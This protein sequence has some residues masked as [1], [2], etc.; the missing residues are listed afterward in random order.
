[1]EHVNGALTISNPRLLS[2]VYFAVL[3][4]I[5]TIVLK[6]ILY[7]LG[8]DFGIALY[9][10]L[11]LSFFCAAV[12]G[13]LFGDEIIH[14]SAPYKNHVFWWAFLMVIVA[15]PLYTFGFLILLIKNNPETFESATLEH[16]LYLYMA[17]FIY[18]LVFAGI[19]LAILAGIAAIFLRGYLVNYLLES[20]YV[21]RTSPKGTVIGSKTPLHG[22][23]QID[24]RDKH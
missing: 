3:A 14:C 5:I 13:A 6:G 20:L 18:A 1:M 8:V 15:L 22:Q 2:A 4:V 9:Q 11:L 21:K 16:Y 23:Q 17:I 12:F 10:F 24:Y 7:L 19:W